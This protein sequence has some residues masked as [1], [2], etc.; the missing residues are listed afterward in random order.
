MP[1]DHDDRFGVGV[2]DVGRRPPYSTR[3]ALVTP[4]P[5]RFQPAECQGKTHALEAVPA[6]SIVL[7]EYRDAGC[8]QVL[9]QPSDHF[10]GFLVVRGAQVNHDT[11]LWVTQ[12]LRT[13]ERSQERNAGV[14]GKGD[15]DPGRGRAH[16]ADESEDLHS[17]D[18]PPGGVNGQVGFVGVVNG[19]Q[20]QPAAVNA[21]SLVGLVER[22]L[23]AQAHLP[24]QF[25]LG[26]PENRG[27]PEHDQVVGDAR[28]RWP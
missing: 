4:R 16:R 6:V 11:Q 3:P 14:V 23:D 15:R 7:I 26:A 5:D 28:F 8:A 9:G 27:L 13:G 2:D 1:A 22:R 12:E 24:A 21:A 18:E 10:L 20:F 19:F 17:L 25:L